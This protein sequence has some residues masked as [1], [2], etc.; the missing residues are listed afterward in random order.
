MMIRKKSK[1]EKYHTTISRKVE[2]LNKIYDTRNE[3]ASLEYIDMT[4][5]YVYDE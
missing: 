2:K 3:D 5:I 1:V 4:D